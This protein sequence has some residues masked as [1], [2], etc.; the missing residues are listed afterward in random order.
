MNTNLI[1]SCYKSRLIVYLNIMNRFAFFNSTYSSKKTMKILMVRLW[2]SILTMFLKMHHIIVQ[3]NVLYF[4]LQNLKY[5]I[6]FSEIQYDT[7]VE[8]LRYLYSDKVDNIE[9]NANRLLPVATR[10]NLPGLVTLCE[11]AL[12][13]SLTPTNVPN[14]LLL[15]DQCGCDNLRKA[16]LN[17]CEDSTEIKENVHLGKI[18]KLFARF[19]IGILYLMCHHDLK[20]QKHLKCDLDFK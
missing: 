1:N 17:Y 20:T 10:Y 6:N 2:R 14:I 11:R 3:L 13:E 12:L 19:I 4:Y 8:L 7:V 16:A 5:S 18:G 9:V 15:A